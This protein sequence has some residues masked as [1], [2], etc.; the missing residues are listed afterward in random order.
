MPIKKDGTGKRWVE[1]EP[2]VP[3]TPEQVWHAMATGGGLAAWFVKGEIE[4]RV[5]G[6]FRLD[7]GQGSVTSGEVTVWEPAHTLG[8]VEREWAPGAPPVATEITITG[9]TGNRCVVRMVHSLFTS[10]EEWDDQ[11]EGFQSGWP[12]FFAILRVYLEHFAGASAASFIVMTSARVDPLSAWVR[13]A[14]AV[15]LAGANVGEHRTASSGPESW[16]GIV[17]HVYQDAQQRYVVLRLDAPSPGVALVGTA[18]A[19]NLGGSPGT[20]LSVCR[21]FYGDDAETGAA[22]SEASWRDWLARSFDTQGVAGA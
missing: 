3:G 19:A 14:D 13:L 20:T 5:G 8:Y 18:D 21:Y 22:D 7:W 16:S 2:I 12:G 4:P 9:R 11:I 1:M 15:G 6:A 17:E 10:S